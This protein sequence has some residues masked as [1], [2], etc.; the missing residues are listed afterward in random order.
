MTPWASL[1][2]YQCNKSGILFPYYRFRMSTE[3]N[4]V[5]GGT[6][7]L[8]SQIDTA[9]LVYITVPLHFP[10]ILEKY[11]IKIKILKIKLHLFEKMTKNM[12]SLCNCL[13]ICATLIK[14]CL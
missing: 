6:I 3:V 4:P 11:Y 10:L 8:R 9:C 2:E 12:F 1:I 14:I 7:C 13:L 5:F